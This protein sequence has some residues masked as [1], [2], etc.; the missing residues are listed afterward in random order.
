MSST[1]SAKGQVTIPKAVR[2]HLGLEPGGAVAFVIT[3]GGDVLL[4]RHFDDARPLRGLLAH[5]APHPAPTVEELDQAIGDEVA[6][7]HGVDEARTS[8]G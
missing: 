5:L 4:Q 3:P 6:C 7:R 8:D 1:V 2:E